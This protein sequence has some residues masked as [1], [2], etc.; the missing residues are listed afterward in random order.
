MPKEDPAHLKE[1]LTGLDTSILDVKIKIAEPSAGS[2]FVSNYEVISTLGSG[3]MSVVYKVRHKMLDKLFALK[4]LRPDRV[5]DET[6]VKRFKLEAQAAS[7]LIHPHI[8]RVTDFGVENEQMRPYLVMDYAE[9]QSLSDLIKQS[10]KLSQDI[11]LDLSI[12]VCSAMEFAHKNGVIHRDLKPSNIM[13]QPDSSKNLH[14]MVV[15]FGIAKLINENESN[16][17]T[18]TGEVFGSPMYMSPEQC[19][20]VPLDGR[21]DIY[22]MGCVLYEMLTGKPPFNAESTIDLLM[23]QVSQPAPP[24]KAAGVSPDMEAVVFKA[25]EKDRSKR[26]QSMADF[27]NDLKAIKQGLPTTAYSASKEYERLKL[28]DKTK[29]IVLR[30]IAGV[31]FAAA[32]I[33][34][35]GKHDPS[36][37]T[38]NKVK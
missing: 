37:M 24:M 16:D 4:L 38:H 1:D 12:Q 17:L 5:L 8:A 6:T 26:Y 15:D 35:I 23:M 10:N 32:A 18:K 29:T 13:V 21:T 2:T 34:F 27:E 22:S 11:A 9:G 25:L 31:A 14:A 19:H 30:S 28:F 33:F 20:G 7:R 3:G 36:A